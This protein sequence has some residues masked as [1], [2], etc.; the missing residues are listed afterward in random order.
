MDTGCGRE[1]KNEMNEHP[2][3][4]PAPFLQVV[5]LGRKDLVLYK[6]KAPWME[7]QGPRARQLGRALHTLHWALGIV[8]GGQ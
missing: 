1:K 3:P 2:L 6:L 7:G 4:T 8:S 5:K